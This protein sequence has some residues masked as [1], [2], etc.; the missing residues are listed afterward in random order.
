MKTRSFASGC[1]AVCCALAVALPSRA[2]AAIDDQQFNELREMIN[3][4]GQKV[5]KQDQRI[6]QLEKTHAQDSQVHEQDQK[7]HEQDQQK[8][9]ELE[10]KL[11]ETQRTVSDVQQ[12]AAMGVPA[13][14]LPRMPLDEAT[15]NHNFS[16]LGDAE[17]QYAKTSGQ[18]G[19]FLFADFA[20]IFLY[21]G[22]DKVLFEAGFDF[23]LQNNAPGSPGATTTID[24]SFAHLDYLMNDYV[25]LVA[26][27]MLLPLGTY[28]E[29]TAGWLNKIPDDPLPRDLLP[30][31]GVGAQLRGAVP[32]GE[33]GKLLNYSV[34]GVNGPGSADGSGNAGALDL[35]G[36]VGLRSD[37]AVANLH[38]NPSGGARVGLFMPF[39]PHYDV[40]L[41]LSG[42]SGEWDDV[43]RHT[44]SGAVA[45]A[46][47]HLGSSIEVKGE[48]IRSWY[49]SDDLGVIHP[50]GWWVQ[51]GYKLAG[52]NLDWP[53][54]NNVELVNRY[55][56][57][58][59]GLGLKTRRY[60]VGY[61]YYI[62]NTLLFEGDY[63]FLHSTDPS[64]KDRLVF[65]LSY[66]F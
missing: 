39:K 50:E 63:E 66:G 7:T 21:R 5:E 16:I 30:G 46:S 55:D 61:I 6:E 62:S 4:L 11:G 38:G 45:D 24:L 51:A 23:A 18:H 13:E 47:L 33:M 58:H 60:T 48:Y 64:E 3:K 20:P 37:N 8:I 26:G 10:K 19:T 17:V 49:G 35:G 15:V 57:I 29:R 25:T 14:P 32:L 31:A 9:Q 36:N 65:Q 43:G 2:A 40:E 54:I 27:D 28:S 52:L 22:G 42:Q 12:K 1:A 53:F 34:W 59:D 41:G 56:S 44:W